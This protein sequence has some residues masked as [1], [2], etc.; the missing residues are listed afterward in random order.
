MGPLR[1]RLTAVS[2]IELVGRAIVLGRFWPLLVFVVQVLKTCRL[3][4]EEVWIVAVGNLPVT[5]E[6]RLDL[7]FFRLHLPVVTPRMSM[8]CES[9]DQ[10]RTATGQQH[11]EQ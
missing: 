9:H 6:V 11:R 1:R 2:R 5:F 7:L 3:H 4:C 10:R 8:L